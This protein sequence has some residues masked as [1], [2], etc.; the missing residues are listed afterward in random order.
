LGV[1]A[2]PAEPPSATGG[3][4]VAL[5]LLAAGQGTRMRSALPKPLH[6]VAGLPMVSHVLRAGAGARPDRTVLVVGR[7]T[8]DLVDRLGADPPPASVLQDPP[9]GTGDAVRRAL[10][11]VGDAAWIV[12]LYAD[13]PLLTAAAVERLVSGARAARARVTVLTAL[14][15]DAAAYGRI[16][17]DPDGHPTRIVERKEDEPARRVGPTEIN[18]GMMV[19]D[20][21]WARDALARLRP[22]TASG[23][24][25][26]TDLVALAVADGV[27]PSGAWPVATVAAE[28]EVALGVNDRVELAAADAV[29]RDRIRRRLMLAGVTLVGPETIFVD[30]G[31]TVGAETT[32]LPFSCLSG[33]TVV[34]AGCTIGPHAV[35]V[36]SRIG[37][38]VVV[39]SST[40]EASTIAD[41]ADVGP[42]AH[43][44][45]GTEIGPRVHVGNYAEL[46]NARL[47]EGVKVGH[48]CYLG[49]VTIG[50][51]TNI[52]AGTVVANFD[53]ARKHQTE[54]GAD[55]FIG[56]D[57][58]LRAPVRVGDRARTG[59]G[60]VVTRDVP[61]DALA[62]GVPARIRGQRDKGKGQRDGSEASQGNDA[63]ALS[64]LTLNLSPRP[65][66]A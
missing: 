45:A 43:L 22:S 48:F 19:L 44:R 57:T 11:A 64:P 31:V 12:V 26:L 38:G 28:A 46:K 39:Q 17:R 40:V 33:G 20:A 51:E 50:A 37:D 66:G 15:P 56:S 13:H 2:G 23:E 55:A 6:P 29:A 34:G 63:S 47:A 53:G 21:A 24:Y 10:D 61:D 49:D 65:E 27:G 52:G 8:R 36:D 14:L 32:I 1:S 42:Y 18:S 35:V 3:D 16:D 62:I 41:G 54:I 25:Y 9:L 58:V 60:S 59:A 5:V 4:G 30:E 7:E